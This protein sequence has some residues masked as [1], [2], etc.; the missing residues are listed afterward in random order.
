MTAG[1]D[2]ERTF[3]EEWAAV[4][5]TV[6]RR[7]GDL[8]A[9]E[10]A[11]AEAFAVAARVWPAEGTPPN[12]GGWLTVTAW[13]KALDQLRRDRPVSTDPALTAG[14]MPAGA[15]PAAAGA[16]SAGPATAGMPGSADEAATGEE[17]GPMTPSQLAGDDRLPMVC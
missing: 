7:L 15:L 11:A 8:Q 12:P 3:R 1:G 4:V 10:E 6:A 13:R 14:A 2:L 17:D 16:G 5:A 9:A